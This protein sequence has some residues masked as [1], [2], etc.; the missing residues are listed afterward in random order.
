MLTAELLIIQRLKDAI[1]PTLPAVKIASSSPIAATVDVALL[2]PLV[3]VHPSRSDKT[4]R[5]SDDLL[6]ER[7]FWQVVVVV[8]NIPAT[9]SLDSNYQEAGALLDLCAKALSGWK[10]GPDFNALEYGGR[11]ETN[12]GNGFSEF[13]LEFSA[14]YAISTAPATPTT[15]NFVTFDSKVDLD[16][17]QT[18]EPV[19]EDTVTLPQ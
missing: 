18:G 11:L 2:C 17:T 3:M 6:V 4:E 19:A 7:Q 9:V 1:Q 13:P 12:V 15:D 5:P 8:K 14:R 16:T 10:P